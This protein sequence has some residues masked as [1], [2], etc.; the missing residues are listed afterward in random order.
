MYES[1][2]IS[3][4]SIE[5]HPFCNALKQLCIR[6]PLE[7]KWLL[8]PSLRIGRAWVDAMAFFGCPTANLHETTL[9]G[10]ARKMIQSTLNHQDMQII[11]HI[12]ELHLIARALKEVGHNPDGYITAQKPTESLVN[13][14]YQTIRSLRLSG[15]G[16]DL[17][18]S[19]VFEV[20]TKGKELLLIRKNYEN[21]LRQN[22]WVDEAES[23]RIAA[24]MLRRQAYKLPK[25][26]LLIKPKETILRGVE[27]DFWQAFPNRVRT[28][29]PHANAKPTQLPLPIS[30]PNHSSKAADRSQITIHRACGYAV[31]I[32]EAIRRCVEDQIPFDRVEILYTDYQT[33]VPI[34][35]E[36]F[37]TNRIPAT[38][39][40]GIPA[41]FFRPGRALLSWL[42]WLRQDRSK[43]IAHQMRMEGL[44]A[45]GVELK[46]ETNIEAI[47]PRRLFEKAA[48]FLNRNVRTSGQQPEY[49]RKELV[50]AIQAQIDCL[51]EEETPEWLVAWDWL[52]RLVHRVRVAGHGPRPGHVYV[53]ELEAGGQ[54]FRPH[55]FVLGLDD[56]RFPGAQMQ[57]PLL[58]DEEKSKLSN[59]LQTSQEKQRR[60]LQSYRYL[61]DRLN[62][63]MHLSY[64]YLQLQDDRDLFASQPILQAKKSSYDPENCRCNPG[65]QPPMAT[66]GLTPDRSDQCISQ[67]EWW[68]VQLCGSDP[69]LNPKASVMEA[70]PHLKHGEAAKK[71]RESDLFTE[72]DGYVPEAGTRY[73][74]Y[75]PSGIVLSAASLETMGR[76]PLEFFF[77]YVLDIALP[78]IYR[79][80]S[81]GWLDAMT[82]GSLLHAVFCEFFET[83][84]KEN[85]TPCW[86][87]DRDLMKK[88]I[89]SQIEQHTTQAHSEDVHLIEKEIAQIENV[90]FIFLRDQESICMECE[91]IWLEVNIGEPP[92][93]ADS[94]MRYIDPIEIRLP[95]GHRIRVKGKIDRVD[96]NKQNP[97]CYRIID[98]KTGS[99][100]KYRQD[101][102]FH[103][104]RILQNVLYT[105]LVETLLRTQL[106]PDARVERFGYYFPSR[107]ECGL[108]VDFEAP[109]LRAG[110]VYIEHLCNLM[111]AGGFPFTD[112]PQDISTSE[113]TACFGEVSTTARQIAK[114]LINPKNKPLDAYRILR[115]HDT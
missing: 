82:R 40:Q 98:Y 37:L 43:Q 101:P 35:V 24:S 75:D 96:R 15:A 54:S 27:L 17:A 74:P 18:D 84:L 13:A 91:P 10:T 1:K 111:S 23:L 60:M 108:Q 14:L 47:S 78:P 22:G 50:D 90:A 62:H 86:E 73:N 59:Q 104:G 46:E 99:A 36:L 65:Y 12:K 103:Q 80:P 83:I 77:R 38:F 48:F 34:M 113:Y 53:T 115:V 11:N 45:D 16:Y 31:E 102:P 57:D 39:S 100:W 71:A 81:R 70:Y 6:H 9:S 79:Q 107:N 26:L 66:C 109:E 3:P 44:L 87:R 20:P 106:A 69:E 25:D 97:Q 72:F 76:C 67:A 8:A 63:R 64:S 89:R 114:K 93:D 56:S 32:R 58:L 68:L 51:T 19:S 30:M 7:E 5:H 28:E 33:Y 2:N 55:T 61:E 112:D 29:L 110:L 95:G 52:E 21:L 92:K 85:Q 88:I 94:G 105:S 4:E 42:T 41:R 49:S